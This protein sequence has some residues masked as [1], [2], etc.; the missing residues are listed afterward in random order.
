LRDRRSCNRR[1]GKTDATDFEK[2]TTLHISFPSV[3]ADTQPTD[4]DLASS[5]LFPMVGAGL[6]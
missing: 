5:C 3:F 6:F 1:R 4:N 2:I